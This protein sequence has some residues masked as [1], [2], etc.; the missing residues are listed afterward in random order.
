MF[1]VLGHSGQATVLSALGICMG[2][3]EWGIQ[4]QDTVGGE[5]FGS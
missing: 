5:N 4:D 2:Y 3:R 1:N